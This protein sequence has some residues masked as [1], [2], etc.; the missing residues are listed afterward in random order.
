M[1]PQCFR[2]AEV[3]ITTGGTYRR[4]N[5]PA[6][7]SPIASGRRYTGSISVRPPPSDAVTNAQAQTLSHAGSS[8]VDPALAATAN[9]T[10]EQSS[11]G[12]GSSYAYAGVAA[13][14]PTGGGSTYAARVAAEQPTF[15]GPLA[16]GTPNAAS[17]L[18]AEEARLRR[19]IAALERQRA[20]EWFWK[21]RQQQERTV[22]DLRRRYE[23]LQRGEDA[24]QATPVMPVGPGTASTNAQ[25]QG[26]HDKQ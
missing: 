23:V 3:I 11:P 2:S 9:R 1:L 21:Q 18:D 5:D 8:A 7:V 12:G 26:G 16:G 19:D 22:V 10:A 13:E 6:Y 15:G 24:V 25:D 20:E 17:D 14:Q 4:N